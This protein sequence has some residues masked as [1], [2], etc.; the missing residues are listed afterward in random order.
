MTPSRAFANMRR[1]GNRSISAPAIISFDEACCRTR[2]RLGRRPHW[3]ASGRH[4]HSHCDDR[5]RNRA[6]TKSSQGPVTRRDTVVAWVA[7]VL[8]GGILRLMQTAQ[9]AFPLGDGGLFYSAIEAVRTSGGLPESIP[10]NGDIPFVYPPLG[11]VV[12]ALVSA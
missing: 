11:F 5:P 6:P 9:S 7:I 8:V 12:A 4:C 2:R 1:D 10:Y 3:R